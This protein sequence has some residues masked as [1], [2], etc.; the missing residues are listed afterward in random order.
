M[1]IRLSSGPMHMYW[2]GTACLMPQTF[3][4]HTHSAMHCFVRVQHRMR[5]CHGLHAMRSL[6]GACTVSLRCNAVHGSVVEHAAEFTER[7]QRAQNGRSRRLTCGMSITRRR[8]REVRDTTDLCTAM[9]REMKGANRGEGT[10]GDL[11]EGRWQM[12]GQTRGLAGDDPRFG[13]QARRC[14]CDCT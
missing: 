2:L 9:N 14:P 3:N 1:G 12:E 5:G 11:N 10:K 4:G 7:G 13:R 6:Q 8:K